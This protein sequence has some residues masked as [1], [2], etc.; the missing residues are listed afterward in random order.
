[1]KIL[2]LGEYSGV[3][4][5]LAVGLREL[6]HHVVVASNGDFWK[7]YPRDIDLSRT[8][9]L[10][11]LWKVG[12]ALPRMRGFDIVQVINPMFMELKAGRLFGVYDWLRG[13]NKRVVMAAVGDDY[14][15]PYI[16]RALKPMRYSDYNIG[17]TDRATAYAEASYLDWVGTE[18]ERL[19]RYIAADC[20]AIVAGTY[21]YWLPFTLT[22]DTDREGGPLKEKLH[23]VPF[24]FTPAAKVTPPPAEK[25]RIF[26]GIQRTRSEFKG[27]DIMLRAAQDVERAH[28]DRVEL[29]IAE[30]VPYETY[31][32]M[33]DTSDV[34]L[35]QIYSYGPGM[36]GLL[37]LSKGLMTV[38]GGEPE[39]YDAMGER[40]C[41]PIINV[42]PTYESVRERLEWLLENPMKWAKIKAE[43]REYVLRNYDCYKVAAQYAQIYSSL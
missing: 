27:T 5:A 15:Y 31:R 23:L 40:D 19:C 13:H 36:N 16:N 41:R 18:K 25:L 38:T 11:M 22:D 28:P 1:M 21:E 17:Q 12:M 14:Y 20:D 10:S 29:R 37:A 6:G 7:N 42:Q 9:R 8:G 35:D 4:S 26:I 39:H 2:L 43:S 32:H 24:P 3:H 34:M 30:N 33:M